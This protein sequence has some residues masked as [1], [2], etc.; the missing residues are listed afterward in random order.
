MCRVRVNEKERV[1]GGPVRCHKEERVMRVKEK[2]QG[3]RLGRDLEEEE[4][5][6][7]VN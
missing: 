6:A 2:K 4:R 3:G 5:A 7:G 1:G